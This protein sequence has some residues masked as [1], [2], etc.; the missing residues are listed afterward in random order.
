MSGCNKLHIN[1]RCNNQINSAQYFINYTILSATANAVAKHI[2][3][4]RQTNPER[5]FSQFCGKNKIIV[6]FN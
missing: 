4:F 2:G 1:T 5:C 3:H 6:E